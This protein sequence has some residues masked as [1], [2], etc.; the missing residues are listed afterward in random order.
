MVQLCVC[1]VFF[2]NGILPLR[3]VDQE[4]SVL[5][6]NRLASLSN[7]ASTWVVLSAANK[8]KV[9]PMVAMPDD[10]GHHDDHHMALPNKPSTITVNS[11][12]NIRLTGGL[13]VTNAFT[14]K[15]VTKIFC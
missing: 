1:Q 3:S 7:T 10:H 4:M 11:M 14:S 6:L 9:K 8:L 12:N 2:L 5:A 13:R 15:L